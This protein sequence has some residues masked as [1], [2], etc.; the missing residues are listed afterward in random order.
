M[1]PVIYTSSGFSSVL[2]NIC[3]HFEWSL[4]ICLNIIILVAFQHVAQFFSKKNWGSTAIALFLMK[5]VLFLT[6]A[7][8]V[9]MSVPA[10]VDYLLRS[11]F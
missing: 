5:C 4:K 2:Q 1:H 9:G 10:E 6:R 11:C 7:V 8:H 3:V